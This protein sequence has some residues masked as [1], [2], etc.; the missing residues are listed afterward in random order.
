MWLIQKHLY[1]ALDYAN[2]R[3][4]LTIAA[5]GCVA[6]KT[7]SG[8]GHVFFVA[9]WES[10]SGKLVWIGGNQSNMVCYALYIE[11]DFQEFRWYGK[12][13]RPAESRY[14]LPVLNGVTS[15]KVTES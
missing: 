5:Y 14:K 3:S 6:I 15:T 12:T 13:N 1:H 9:G 10:K 4:K 7:R 11:S 2:Y 8:G